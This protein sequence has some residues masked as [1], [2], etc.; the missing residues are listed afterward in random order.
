MLDRSLIDLLREA[1]SVYWAGSSPPLGRFEASERIYN[2][3]S[4][5]R[6]APR[7]H[8]RFDIVMLV[9]RDLGRFKAWPLIVDEALRLLK[10]GGL[11]L[12]RFFNGP[13]FSVFELKHLLHA[14]TAGHI[15]PEL[16]NYYPQSGAV[17]AGFRL[18][19]GAQR[20][21][22]IDAV[23][24]G[25]ISDGQETTRLHTFLDSVRALRRPDGLHCETLV[26]GPES[27]RTTVEARGDGTRLIVQ[28]D[29]FLQQGWVTRKKNQLVANMSCPLVV[30]AHD[31][32]V[33]PPDFLERLM[34]F[35]GDFDVLV[36][37]QEMPDG[38]RFPDWVTYGSSW[39]GTFAA[40]LPYGEWCRYLYV[41]GGLMIARREVLSTIGWNELL[42]W[43]QYEDVELTRRMQ[44]QGLVPRLA[45]SVRVLTKEVRS[46][47]IEWF[48]TLPPS[49][50][51]FLLT[52]STH[53]MFE[54]S[55]HVPASYRLGTRI[56]VGGSDPSRALEEG[57]RLGQEW[58]PQRS[59]ADWDGLGYAE[60]FVRLQQVP[61]TA[62]E[63]RCTF[64]G[65]GAEMLEVLVNWVAM[66]TSVAAPGEVT[67][68]IPAGALNTPN[69]HI[70]LRRKTVEK[71]PVRLT[72]FRLVQLLEGGS[73]GGRRV[74]RFAAGQAD[75]ALLGRN[76]SNP[77]PWGVW[78]IAS[79]AEVT[80]DLPDD[81]TQ[82][83]DLVIEAAAFVAPGKPYR[84]CG[85]SVDGVPICY[86]QMRPEVASYKVAVPQDL[87][88]GTG[89]LHLSFR[90]HGTLSPAGLG[91]N[92]DSRTLG[93][94]LHSI[95]AAP[96]PAQ[97]R[98][99][100]TR[101]FPM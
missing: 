51:R 29:D 71:A 14:W 20:P 34:E 1:G 81:S 7:L 79:D 15:R 44:A 77:E 68:Q 22:T 19:P 72:S 38:R 64:A 84:I 87:I 54:G 74:F 8:R 26:C 95:A 89:Q 42:F 5:F 86:L 63:L 60:L 32:Y 35:G 67:I 10:P 37:R 41:N 40:M 45:R 93:V 66:Q 25:V 21:A 92:D 83:L 31:R 96:A 4:D 11:L 73:S 43:N 18:L 3:D 70:L 17:L 52:Q 62:V 97:H 58:T 28:S 46:R 50:D 85:I 99:S 80:L 65:D 94:G 78:S 49:P 53:R 47:Y 48:E 36:C 100:T 59:G 55:E 101:P 39:R 69:V 98:Q 23:A 91:L 12:L 82:G 13:L 16:E 30:I 75:V 56:R 2:P 27:L 61:T 88:S 6:E 33:I 90:A 9:E 57:L 76:W 24:F